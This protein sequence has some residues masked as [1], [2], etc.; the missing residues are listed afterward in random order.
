MPGI[1][2]T[3]LG[4]SSTPTRQY[5]VDRCMGDWVGCREEWRIWVYVAVLIGFIIL[6]NVSFNV[7]LYTLGREQS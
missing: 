7:L 5:L 6:F 4:N 1:S 3:S 2:L